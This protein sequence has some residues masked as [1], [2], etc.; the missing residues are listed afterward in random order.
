MFW[1]S[2]KTNRASNANTEDSSVGSISYS[3][4]DHLTEILP[5]LHPSADSDEW[6]DEGSVQGAFRRL[7]VG[8]R[9]SKI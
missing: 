1:D 6:M 5:G 8:Q 3:T 4:S 9:E 7:D 2:Y